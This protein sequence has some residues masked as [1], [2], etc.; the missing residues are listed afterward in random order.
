MSP[1]KDLF[2]KEQKEI[3]I[4]HILRPR[5]L[6]NVS[7]SRADGFFIVSMWGSRM[8]VSDR[9]KFKS[10]YSISGRH[11]TRAIN[12]LGDNLATFTTTVNGLDVSL[13]F[14]MLKHMLLNRIK[15]EGTDAG[16]L[17]LMY[18]DDSDKGIL[19]MHTVEGVLIKSVI[20]YGEEVI[21][22]GMK[23]SF[24]T[25]QSDIS[26][27]Y[28]EPSVHLVL[29]KSKKYEKDKSA[30]ISG[31]LFIWGDSSTKFE[32]SLEVDIERKQMTF[33]ITVR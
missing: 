32:I 21:F 7:V 27:L 3:A 2:Y 20:P 26:K 1:I 4:K 11:D 17:F 19:I 12:M 30:N 10:T 9:Q 22:N 14:S 25:G 16:E 8:M 13:T 24:D 29:D 33:E 6:E 31:V 23:I 5:W 18:E 28:D 15:N